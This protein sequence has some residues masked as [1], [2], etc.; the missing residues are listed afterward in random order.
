MN[1]PSTTRWQNRLWGGEVWSEEGY[2]SKRRF[3][4]KAMRFSLLC[5]AEH[6]LGEKSRAPEKSMNKSSSKNPSQSVQTV[7]SRAF[8]FL[9]LKCIVFI[10]EPRNCPL[11]PL[12][13]TCIISHLFCSWSFHWQTSMRALC[14][15]GAD[16]NAVRPAKKQCEVYT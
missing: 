14:I 1:H 7:T 15:A 16:L 4:P 8:Y 6:L 12:L 9:F 13:S 11:S 5:A 3:I 10:K 2:L